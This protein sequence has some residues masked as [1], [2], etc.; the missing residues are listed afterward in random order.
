MSAATAAP[1]APALPTAVHLA[2]LDLLRRELMDPA[3][4]ARLRKFGFDVDGLARLEAVRTRTAAALEPRWIA[5]YE[6]LQMRYGRAVAAV[7]SRVCLGCF[8]TLPTTARAPLDSDTHLSV[9]E[10]CGRIHYWG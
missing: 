10:S 8:V 6:R 9:C 4:R 5:L 1:P 2:D 7:R 3:A